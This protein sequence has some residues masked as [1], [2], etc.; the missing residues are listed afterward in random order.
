MAGLRVL[1][2]IVN[3]LL[4][5]AEQVGDEG[6]L[7]DWG[8]NPLH[9]LA[10]D[11]M[12]RLDP[13]RKVLE[14]GAQSARL[15]RHQIKPAR[16]RARLRDGLAQQ[17]GNHHRVRPLRQGLLRQF[18]RQLPRGE[19]HAHQ[20]LAQAVMQVLADAPLLAVADLGN[21]AFETLPGA[22]VGEHN[23][24]A[25]HLSGVIHQGP[26]V[27]GEPE[28][29]RR[30]C[31]VQEHFSPVHRFPAHGP[32]QRILPARRL[33][34][35]IGQVV[36]L[37]GQPRHDIGAGRRN[38]EHAP[39]RWVDVHQAALGVGDHHPIRHAVENRLQNIGLRLQVGLGFGQ[40][41]GPFLG[42]GAAFGDL[43]LQVGI[44]RLQLGGALPDALLQLLLRL[45]QPLLHALPLNH[46]EFQGGDETEQRRADQGVPV[47]NQRVGI[48][49]VSRQLGPQPRCA[50]GQ[51]HA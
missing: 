18:G 24:S 42:R 8:R 49:R 37:R 45:P 41:A 23:D 20:V 35:R 3:R 14:R 39:R 40:P 51:G 34:G 5:D 32:D 28:A 44:Q 11:L 10:L 30:V 7:D 21:L 47:G 25:G 17:L 12:S 22:D 13:H 1:D 2:G 15:Q 16:H 36:L 6:F 31:V 29:G 4:G 46:L 43:F 26:A 48:A 9:K 19:R 38:P 27:H 33:G 50:A